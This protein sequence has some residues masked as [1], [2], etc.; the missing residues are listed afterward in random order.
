MDIWMVSDDGLS[1]AQV[2]NDSGDEL[3]PIFSPKNDAVFYFEKNG[4]KYDLVYVPVKEKVEEITGLEEEK[5]NSP[6]N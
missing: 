6:T 2:S 4:G 3:C 1:V 5:D